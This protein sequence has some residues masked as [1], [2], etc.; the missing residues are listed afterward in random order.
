MLINNATWKAYISKEDIKK[1][2]QTLGD[3]IPWKLKSI[4][5]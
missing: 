4:G 1:K 5:P 2:S 3:L